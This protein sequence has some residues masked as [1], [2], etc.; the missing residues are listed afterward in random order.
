M[1]AKE[2]AA[3]ACILRAGQ[4]VSGRKCFLA[5]KIDVWMSCLAATLVR[6]NALVHPQQQ[7]GE[8][9]FDR[10]CGNVHADLQY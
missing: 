7:Q 6:L 2:A 8:I 3:Q 5:H 1:A 9:W 4:P 10:K